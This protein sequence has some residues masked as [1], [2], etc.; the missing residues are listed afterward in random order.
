MRVRRVRLRPRDD[1]GDRSAAYPV[2]NRRRGEAGP[3]LCRRCSCDKTKWMRN[4]SAADAGP[5]QWWLL[6]ISRTLGIAPSHGGQG[7]NLWS[8]FSTTTPVNILTSFC[9]PISVGSRYGEPKKPSA[10]S[11]APG[12][13]PT[14]LLHMRGQNRLRQVPQALSPHDFNLADGAKGSFR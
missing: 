14:K 6:L 4:P 11:L 13:K 9:G 3:G 12:P 8:A 1:A 5:T 7:A 2:Q 10:W